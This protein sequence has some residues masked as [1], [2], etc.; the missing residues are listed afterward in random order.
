MQVKQEEYKRCRF[1]KVWFL[2]SQC[3]E[4]TKAKNSKGYVQIVTCPRC[5]NEIKME[6]RRGK[7]TWRN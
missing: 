2:P 6:H 4:I 7:N 5:G 3:A 1:C